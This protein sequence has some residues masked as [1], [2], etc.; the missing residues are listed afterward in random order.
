MPIVFTEIC[1]Y[2][3]L[4]WYAL[5]ASTQFAKWA[6]MLHFKNLMNQISFMLMEASTVAFSVYN[7]CCKW[8]TR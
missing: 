4:A 8:H 1:A 5:Y 2:M 7:L 6:R 3:S